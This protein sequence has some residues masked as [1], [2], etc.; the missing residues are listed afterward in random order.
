MKT[1]S[2]LKL[3]PKTIK[4]EDGD[5]NKVSTQRKSQMPCTSILD[6]YLKIDSYLLNKKRC[7]YFQVL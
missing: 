4:K 1:K 7:N 5:I 2:N 6:S 3:S